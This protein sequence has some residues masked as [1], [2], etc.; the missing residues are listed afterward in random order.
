MTYFIIFR[1]LLRKG[2]W[3]TLIN[4]VNTVVTSFLLVLVGLLMKVNIFFGKK[5]SFF[6]LKLYLKSLQQSLKKILLIRFY[7]VF[8]NN[9]Y[10]CFVR[11]FPQC[12][13]H[14]PSFSTLRSFHWKAGQVY[15]QTCKITKLTVEIEHNFKKN[16]AIVVFQ[17]N[18][19]LTDVHYL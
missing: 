10:L 15:L 13:D 8:E 17:R 5:I 1:G 2:W 19:F 12:F 3:L 14:G 18:R 6:F 4:T 11:F 9:N 16:G 7:Q